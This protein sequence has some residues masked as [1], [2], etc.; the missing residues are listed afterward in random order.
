MDR[1]AFHRLAGGLYGSVCSGLLA[2]ASQISLADAA[3][4]PRSRL[5]QSSGEPLKPYDLKANEAWVFGYPF[6][7]TPCFLIRSANSD[8]ILAFSAICTHKMTHPSRPI[9]HIA[10]RDAPVVFYDKSGEKQERRG[11]ISCCSERSVYD[12]DNGAEVL[13]GPAPMPLPRIGLQISDESIVAVSSTGGEFYETFLD[14]FG[15]R[16]AIEHGISDV[17]QRVGTNTVA[18]P[19][20]AYSGQVIQC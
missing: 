13:A 9:S 6:V 5:V 1:R 10:Y 3:P 14:T 7:A 12:P 4:T 15:F 18:E 19:A 16:L 8:N 2:G 11:L 17:R 20:A